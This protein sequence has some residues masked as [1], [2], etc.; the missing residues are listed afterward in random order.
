[1]KLLN[2]EVVI[3]DTNETQIGRGESLEDTM[4]VLSRY[5]DIVVYRGQARIN[6]II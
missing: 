5:V 1:M 4:R 2:G 3:L 6:F